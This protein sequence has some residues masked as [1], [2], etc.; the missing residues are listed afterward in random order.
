MKTRDFLYLLSCAAVPLPACAPASSAATQDPNAPPPLRVGVSGNNEPLIFQSGRG[1][2][3]GVEA[4]FARMLGTETGRQARFVSMRFDR[5]IPA[6]ERGD[7]DII[8]SG[9]TVTAER[10]SLVDFTTPY[11]TSGQ[12]LLVRSG[13]AGLFQDPRLLFISPFRIGVEQGA[14]GEAMAR[15]LHADSTVVPYATPAR[16]ASA[17][18]SDRVD[19]VL[20]D[21]PV[22]WRLTM[23]NP[24]A[25]YRVIPQLL[26]SERLAWAVRRGNSTLL[27]QAN[28]AIEKW[29][30]NGMLHRT[31]SS[32]MPNYQMLKRM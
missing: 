27:A 7:I 26:T 28:S 17:L 8:M 18:L 13:R 9:L 3:S 4:T 6:L 20:H 31:I 24:S 1:E 14:I 11:M 2:F 23:R 21:A 29:R 32:Y 10:R 22:L 5:L 16:A 15:R 25:D 12:A 19:V 30:K